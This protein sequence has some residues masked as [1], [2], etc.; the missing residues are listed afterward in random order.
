MPLFE[1]KAKDAAGKIVADTIQA[2][3]REDAATALRAMNLQVLT[4]NNLETGVIIGGGISVADKALFCRFMATMLRSGLSIPES[5]EIIRQETT[6]PKMKKILADLAFQTQKGKTLTSVL[7]QYK[8]DFDP[9]FLTMVKVGEESGSLDKSFEYLTTQLTAAHELNQ[10]V[11]GSMMYPA[12]I[13]VAMLGNGIIMMVFV[14]P[15]IAGVFLKLDVPL[16]FVTKV[17]L[18]TGD[19]IG[20]NTILFLASMALGFGAVVGSFYLPATRRVLMRIVRKLPLVKKI[21]NQLDI[22]RFAR[23]LSTLLHSGVPITS[24]LDVSV[25]GLSDE[26]IRAQAKTFSEGVAR[27]E[28]LSTVLERNTKLFPSI[29]IQTIKAGEKTGSLDEIL[30]EMAQFYESEVD[31]SLKRAT[32]LLEPILMLLIGVVVGA[33]VIIM[34]APIYGIIGG[35][36]QQVGK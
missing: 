33:M 26:R 5:I 24:A 20:K 27:G 4:V 31:Y 6:K 29:M 25:E 11:K 17:I 1:Y 32:S 19:F 30:Q 22:A 15:R 3:S 14:L 23:T 21:V 10:K 18:T 35:L 34:I 2:T 7:S 8:S 16:P 13:C 28:S 9:I 12:V 36:Q